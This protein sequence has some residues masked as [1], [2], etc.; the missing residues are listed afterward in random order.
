MHTLGARIAALTALIVM[1]GLLGHASPP[2]SGAG[3]VATIPVG[4]TPYGI[5]VTPDG[6]QVYVSNSTGGSVSVM[7]T[8]SRSVIRTVTANVGTTPVGIAIN[9]SGT[10]AY[11]GNYNAGD[12]PTSGRITAINTATG[13][14]TGHIIQ[15]ATGAQ[16]RW[17]L[18]LKVSFNGE[19]LYLACQD[20]VR[21]Q[22]LDLPSL[23]TGRLLATTE[24]NNFPSD[25]AVTFDDSTLLVPVNGSGVNANKALFI[26]VASAPG[27]NTY[28]SPVT[29][30]PF[31]VAISPIS[32][33]AYLAGGASGAISVVNPA[34]RLSAEPDI[35]VG[36]QLS[37]IV[38]TP[39][40]RT[41]IVSVVDRNE[42][43]V[44]DLSS[45][46]ISATLPVG[47]GP[48]SIALSPN[49]RTLYTA[50]RNSNDVSI[51]LLPAL[52][53]GSATGVTGISGDGQVNVSWTPPASDGGDVVTGYE[54]TSTP[55]GSSCATPLTRCA[56]TGLTNGIGYT[57]SVTATNAV[58][59]GA[60]SA[61]S[62]SVTPRA[63]NP[64]P[65]PNPDPNPEPQS[66]P[67]STPQASPTPTP[68]P[69]PTLTPK[70]TVGVEPP[71]MTEVARMRSMTAAQIRRLSAE[72]LAAFPP[73]AFAVMTFGQ[74][75]A[76]QPRQVNQ[77]SV[78]QI[79]AIAPRS[80]R[81]MKPAT[82]ARLRVAQ[83]RALTRSQIAQLRTAQLHALGPTKR[84]VLRVNGG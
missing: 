27:T 44:I 2:V 66:E 6:S 40:G 78:Q 73:E 18:N 35:P 65:D 19:K 23:S 70:P 39:D 21:V 63:P 20:D 76:V 54:V 47:N 33:L 60:A 69:T 31:S 74:V 24:N 13:A 5:A 56:V 64:T 10:T 9:P 43:K 12:F 83:T 37:D 38:I 22:E 14:S 80:L 72:Q 51:V 4:A 7:D 53:P 32:G 28:L 49:G 71:W 62:A 75:K 58:G 50:N 26:T 81:A 57:F 17:L 55:G 41:A 46:V 79:Q 25:L 15:T 59:T 61:P 1:F 82:L 8:M 67:P 3:V 34:T 30:G 48:Q 42:V 52:T 16:C 84:K 36:G 68:S 11:V 77:L 45:R 29:T